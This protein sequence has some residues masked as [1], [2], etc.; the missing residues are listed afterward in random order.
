MR[1]SHMNDRMRQRGITDADIAVIQ[2]LGEWNERADRI[3]LTAR[4]CA[5][6]ESVLRQEIRNAERRAGRT[7]IGRERGYV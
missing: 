2:E 1:T 6:A 3:V 4:G 7:Q 5:L